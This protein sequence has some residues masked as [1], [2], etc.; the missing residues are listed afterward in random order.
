[1]TKPW[2]LHE[3]TIRELY[4]QHTLAVV[5]QIM[6]ERYNFKAST[7][8][9]R[10]RLI[11]WGVRKYNSK[12]RSDRGSSSGSSHDD[13]SSGSDTASPKLPR[14]S[15]PPVHSMEQ[16]V[17]SRSVSTGQLDMPSQTVHSYSATS[18][19][20]AQYY[21]ESYTKDPVLMATPHADAQYGWGL[22]LT[23]TA[24][25]SSSF[26]QAESA[27]PPPYFGYPLSP[28]M[29]TYASTVPLD[30]GHTNAPVAYQ[31]PRRN[32]STV[33]MNPPY[34]P[35]RGY[36]PAPPVSGSG[37]HDGGAY[38]H[39]EEQDVKPSPRSD[40]GG[41]SPDWYPDRGVR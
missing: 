30:A 26:S 31:A 39:L 24:T 27:V 7:R 40:M 19:G 18:S 21:A 15:L 3:A 11:R 36:G 1:M 41:C 35:A 13:C 33:D 8:A 17:G 16:Q 14:R 22:P 9:Y 32:H 4:A 34:M 20:H 38:E 5:R 25:S 10:G 29:S 37:E 12:K 2:E 23:Q 6:I 28:P